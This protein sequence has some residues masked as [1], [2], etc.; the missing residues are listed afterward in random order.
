MLS[1]AGLP[2]DG[3]NKAGH[4]NLVTNTCFL[5]TEDI[6]SRTEIFTVGWYRHRKR[7]PRVAKYIKD[8]G[9]PGFH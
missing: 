4:T 8:S 2:N 6:T 9:A 7:N 1:L 3:F 5:I